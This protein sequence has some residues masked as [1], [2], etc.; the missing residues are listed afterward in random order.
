MFTFNCK[1]LLLLSLKLCPYLFV[2]IFAKTYSF[3]PLQDVVK[4]SFPWEGW[5]GLWKWQG[6]GIVKINGWGAFFWQMAY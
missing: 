5:V 4:I 1:C 6:D 3:L 2:T